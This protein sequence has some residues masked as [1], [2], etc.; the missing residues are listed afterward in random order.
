ML[1]KKIK[2]I[3][4]YS[5]SKTQKIV[6]IEELSE[7][8][9]E[10]TKDLRYEQSNILEEWCDCYIMLKQLAIIYNLNE[11]E[12]YDMVCNKIDRTYERLKIKKYEG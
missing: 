10:I 8:I 4:Q 3:V 2:R 9:K 6:A 11:K 1:E 7:L 12:I 5:T